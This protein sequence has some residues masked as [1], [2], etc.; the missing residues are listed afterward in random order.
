MTNIFFFPFFQC[1]IHIYYIIKQWPLASEFSEFE[2]SP[3]MAILA[4]NSPFLASAS[5]R[6]NG[7]FWK[8]AR[9]ARLA[10]I[11]QTL[12][13]GL[14]RLADIHQAIY[15][16]LARLAD[17]RQTILRGLAR[18]TKGEFGECYVNLASL[19]NLAN[20]G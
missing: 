7:H 15:R 17:I 19:A 2:Y 6:Q 20:V 11:R 9:L 5:P 3:K 14:A 4:E 16:V 18:L 1:K 13:R 8:Y 10:D 12:Y